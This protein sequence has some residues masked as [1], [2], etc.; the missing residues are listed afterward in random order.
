MNWEKPDK[1]FLYRA[2]YLV[3]IWLLKPFTIRYIIFGD[4]HIEVCEFISNVQK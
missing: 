4:L 1:G 3:F 2:F